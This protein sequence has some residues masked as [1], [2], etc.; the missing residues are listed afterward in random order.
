MFDIL[1]LLLQANGQDPEMFE[2][3]ADLVLEV[4]ITHPK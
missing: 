3:P 4:N 1:P 2:V